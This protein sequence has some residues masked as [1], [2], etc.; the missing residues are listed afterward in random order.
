MQTLCLRTSIYHHMHSAHSIHILDLSILPA[1]YVYGIQCPAHSAHHVHLSNL[2]THAKF[3]SMS[4][5][6][7]IIV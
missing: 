7:R 3:Q 2:E 6:L 4:S 5:G 1:T